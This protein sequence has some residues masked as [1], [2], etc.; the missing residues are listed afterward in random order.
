MKKIILLL[1]PVLLLSCK[2]DDGSPKVENITKG[3]KWNLKIGSSYAQVYTQLQQ[4]GTE[5]KFQ[6]LSVVK[7]QPVTKPE[8]L[9]NRLAY[10]RSVNVE[11]TMGT[12]DWALIGIGQEKIST[13]YATN[14]TLKGA[15]KWPSDLPDETAIHPDDPLNT[16]YTRLVA[17]FQLPKYKGQYRLSLSDKPLDKPFDP[18]MVNYDEWA[19]TFHVDIGNTLKSG[20]SSVRLYFKNGKL[21]KIQHTYEEFDVYI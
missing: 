19:F 3:S 15:A 2:K 12:L 11:N 8:E 20:R 18:N 17:I 14:E 21:D 1:I 4:L 5:K 13:I 9:Q 16:A 10:Y 7:Q 6:D